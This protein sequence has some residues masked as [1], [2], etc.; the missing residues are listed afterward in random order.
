MVMKKCK[1]HQRESRLKNLPYSLRTYI[2]VSMQLPLQQV[3]FYY[4]CTPSNNAESAVSQLPSVEP[5]PSKQQ[6]R[7][8]QQSSS[9]QPSLNHLPLTDQTNKYFSQDQEFTQDSDFPLELP[10]ELPQDLGFVDKWPA[11]LTELFSNK[12]DAG[13]DNDVIIKKVEQ[14]FQGISISDDKTKAVEQATRSQS[15]SAEWKNQRRGQLTASSFHDER[16]YCC[17]YTYQ[18]S[19]G[20]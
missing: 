11:P 4:C 8:Q 15:D 3:F 19:A 9:I 13:V 16:F 14:I 5:T 6:L 18:T 2:T 1:L 12:F 17:Q 7:E 10:Q 20:L